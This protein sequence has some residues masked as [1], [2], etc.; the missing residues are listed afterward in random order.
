MTELNNDGRKIH[1]RYFYLV[2]TLGA[3]GDCLPLPNGKS[4]PV[5]K[6]RFFNSQCVAM[7]KTRYS[8]TNVLCQTRAT[9]SLIASVHTLKKK[10]ADVRIAA[11]VHAICK[12]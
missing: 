4:A 11:V 5:P 9:G 6:F 12:V 3:P 10:A 8:Q 2:F 7:P 1:L